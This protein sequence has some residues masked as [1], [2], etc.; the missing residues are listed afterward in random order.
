MYTYW[1]T[2]LPKNNFFST[3]RQKQRKIFFKR[4]YQDNGSELKSLKIKVNVNDTYSPKYTEIVRWGE[5][6]A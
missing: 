4:T 6:E 2:K 1:T 5:K 3:G